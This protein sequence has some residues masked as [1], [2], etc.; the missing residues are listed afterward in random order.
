MLFSLGYLVICHPTPLCSH[1]IVVLQSI[2]LEMGC[3]GQEELA[4]AIGAEMKL[5]ERRHSTLW[6]SVWD[7]W[8]FVTLPPLRS[9]AFVA[10]QSFMFEIGSVVK[11]SLHVQLEV[12]L[13]I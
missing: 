6:C 9:H 2:M 5:L 10:M 13:S 12:K 3:V 7:I 4:C 8:S 1:A 11:G